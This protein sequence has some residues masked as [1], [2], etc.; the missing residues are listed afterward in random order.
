MLISATIPVIILSGFTDDYV[1]SVEKIP[2]DYTLATRELQAA[3]N[4][5][6]S[7]YPVDVETCQR[8]QHLLENFNG[9]AQVRDGA[10]ESML[11]DIIKWRIAN[12]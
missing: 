5:I 3:Q 1:E 10:Q 9:I 2:S 12:C 11:S 6:G 7:T 4:I 8:V